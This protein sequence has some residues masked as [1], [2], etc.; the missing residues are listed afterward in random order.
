MFGVLY[1]QLHVGFLVAL[2]AA[3]AT[4]VAPEGGWGPTAAFTKSNEPGASKEKPG[5]LGL[6]S[7]G[8][9]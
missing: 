8:E 3:A 1:R 7:R 6:S 4:W 2:L 9:R 5:L